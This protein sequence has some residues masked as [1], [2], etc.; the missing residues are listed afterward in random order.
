ML[1]PNGA[2][3][4]DNIGCIERDPLS[5]LIHD[6]LSLLAAQNRPKIIHTSDDLRGE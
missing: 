2:S 6:L 5:I 4:S 3:V 1:P